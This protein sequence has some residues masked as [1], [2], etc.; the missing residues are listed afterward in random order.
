MFYG[1]HLR[2]VREGSSLFTSVMD[3]WGYFLRLGSVI[4]LGGGG[5]GCPPGFDCSLP[6]FC[7]G[8]GI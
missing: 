1:S 5:R 2:G 6:F 8:L 7:L 4:V 3:G